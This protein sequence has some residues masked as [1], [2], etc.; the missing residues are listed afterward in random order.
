M[1]SEKILT[2]TWDAVRAALVRVAVYV[3]AHEWGMDREFA[4]RE[5]LGTDDEC[6]VFMTLAPTDAE[7]FRLEHEPSG[8]VDAFERCYGDVRQHYS[9]SGPGAGENPEAYADRIV[10]I[11]RANWGAQRRCPL[12]LPGMLFVHATISADPIFGE[13]VNA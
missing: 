5:G 11:I 7:V 6:R 13:A 12:P 3:A 4:R 8:T 9:L 1:S 10:G 2:P